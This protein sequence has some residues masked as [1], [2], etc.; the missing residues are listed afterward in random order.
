MLVTGFGDFPIRMDFDLVATGRETTRILTQTSTLFVID[1]TQGPMGSGG[2]DMLGVF[3]FTGSAVRY[4]SD[5]VPIAGTITGMKFTDQLGQVTFN[6]SELNL[7]A[8]PFYQAIGGALHGISTNPLAMLLP[9]NDEFRG[10]AGDDLIIDDAGHNIFMGGPG[11][12][13]IGGGD[14]NDHIYGQSPGGGEDDGDSLHGRGGSDY[15]Q[16]NAGQDDL[17]GGDGSDRLNGGQGRDFIFGRAGNDTI[18]GNRDGDDV[19]GG[20]GNDLIRG[21]Q[22]NDA[23]RGDDGDDIIMGDRGADQIDGGSGEDIFVFG[24]GTSEIG[25]TSE[26]IDWLSEFRFGEDHMS[27]GFVPQA[28]LHQLNTNDDAPRTMDAARAF[29]QAQFDEHAG[30]HEAAIVHVSFG[31]PL[32]F[33]SSTGGST[34]DSVV[35]ISSTANSTS[36]LRDNFDF[37]T[38]DFI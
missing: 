35:Q 28:I 16:G 6:V 25:S 27:L 17:D 23:L 10:T 14:G 33:W 29:A 30:D 21:G 2:Y 22:G 9:G 3:T 15:I 13:F 1:T 20:D 26:D 34:I 32:F 31:S 36:D 12:D 18:N 19:S 7:P 8:A 37:L 11:R 5:N 24:P 38:S 4:N